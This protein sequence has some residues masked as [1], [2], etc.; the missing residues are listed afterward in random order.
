MQP[1]ATAVD[2]L[3]VFP[4]LDAKSVLDQLKDELPTYL[5]KSVDIDPNLSCL[6]WWK[7]NES[8]LPG[9]SAAAHKIFLIQPSSAALERV[10]SLLNASFNDQQNQS[11]QHYVGASIMLQYNHNKHQF[12]HVYF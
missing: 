3:K 5:V 9:W 7:L 4:F 6:E 2:N 8:P 1:D 10:F 12:S 11:L